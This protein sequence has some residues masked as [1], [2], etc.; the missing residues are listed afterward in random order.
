MLKNAREIISSNP[1][2]TG[3]N[4]YDGPWNFALI[5][6]SASI[7]SYSR[8]S[9]LTVS[10]WMNKRSSQQAKFSVAHWRQLGL[11][12]PGQYMVHPKPW[13]SMGHVFPCLVV[14]V[15]H[16][17][18]FKVCSHFHYPLPR[19]SRRPVWAP[20]AWPVTGSGWPCTWM[21]NPPWAAP[22]PVARPAGH[23]RSSV[24]GVRSAGHFWVSTPGK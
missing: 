9:C 23:E 20:P 13:V 15:W 18:N 1:Y 12:S 11:E 2:S 10:H 24:P 5:S 6:C 14:S 4:G 19:P 17:G 7:T 16:L 8:G 22:W 21:V 3:P